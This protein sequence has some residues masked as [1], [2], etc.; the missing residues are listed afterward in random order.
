MILAIRTDSDTAELYLL[1]T[2]KEPQDKEVW[3]AGRQLSI[4]I[5]RRIK[6]LLD[7]NKMDFNDLSGVVMFEG[8]GSFTG[9]RIG[10]TVGNTIAYAQNVPAVT[11]NSKDWI[12]NGI[13]KLKNT[14]PG[15]YPTPRY[16]KAPNITKPKK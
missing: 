10:I 3:E 4:D 7:R 6:D 11:S 16:G 5:L 2:G 12:K 9:L 13:E 15:S 1:Q 14:K 8:P